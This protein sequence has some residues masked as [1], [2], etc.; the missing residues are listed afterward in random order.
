[1]GMA[2]EAYLPTL[3][4]VLGAAAI[5]SINPC[6]IGVLILMVSVL[7]ATHQSTK[8]M[9]LLGGLYIFAV[10]ITYLLAGLGLMYFLSGLPLYLSEYIAITVGIIIIL[11]GLFE[12]KDYFWYGRWFSLTIPGF[13]AKRIHDYASKVTVP[14]IILLGAFVSAVELPCTGAP[15]LAII[16]LL[17]QY[18]DFS[19]FLMLVL[20]NIIFVAPLIV[21]LI[22]VAAGKKLHEVK[23][24]KQESRGGMRLLI[25]LTLVA[26]GWLLMLIANGTI[27]FG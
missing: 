6:A 4:T 2:V 9:L 1:M 17:S 14:G 22:M 7:L 18:F 10:F 25:G 21:I 15:Y 19:A 20:Y 27:N 12:I 5:D 26:M 3:A 13:F 16:T 8:K 24:W 23:K 11:A